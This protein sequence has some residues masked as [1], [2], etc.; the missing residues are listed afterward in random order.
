VDGMRHRVLAGAFALGL[1]EPD[2][3]C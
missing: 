3:A 1:L 2:S